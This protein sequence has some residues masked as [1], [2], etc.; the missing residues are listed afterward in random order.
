MI[1]G[2]MVMMGFVLSGCG[3][4]KG[5]TQIKYEKGNE[6]TTIGA[7]KDGVYALYTASDLTPKVRQ[8]LSAGDKIGFEKTSDGR[9]RA[10]AG[11]Y[12]QAFAGRTAEADFELD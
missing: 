7:P 12:K 1:L 10:V 5:E 9:V 3:A 4:Q 11:T 6:P 2:C 8:K